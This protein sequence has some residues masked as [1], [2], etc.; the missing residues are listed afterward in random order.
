MAGPVRRDEQKYRPA[1]GQRRCGPEATLGFGAGGAGGDRFGADLQGQF[2]LAGRGAYV[3]DFLGGLHHS[4]IAHQVSRTDK[5]ESVAEN[6]PDIDCQALVLERD[7]G[8]L[9]PQC[10]QVR[11]DRFLVVPGQIIADQ[12][13]RQDPARTRPGLARVATDDPHPGAVALLRLAGVNLNG[14]HGAFPG[15][16]AR[17]DGERQIAEAPARIGGPAADVIGVDRG[18]DDQRLNLLAIH[19]FV[20]AVPVKQHR[21]IPVWDGSI[22]PSAR[23]LSPCAD[24]DYMMPGE[25]ACGRNMYCGDRQIGEVGTAD[26]QST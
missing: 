25:V 4:D 10:R 15:V 23:C 22:Y 8:L 13:V 7:A 3:G 12:R 16:V 20:G 11:R 18:R 5:T 9:K 17:Q 1:A 21:W 2:G 19:D 14:Q 24:P 6:G 26:D